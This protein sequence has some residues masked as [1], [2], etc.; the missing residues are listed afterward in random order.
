MP[1]T[2]EKQSP[3]FKNAGKMLDMIDNAILGIVACGTVAVAVA[4]LFDLV[5]DVYKEEKHSFTH[6]LGELMFV[7]IIMELFRQVVRQICRQPFSLQPFMT[8][9]VI[10]C[11]RGLLITQMKIGAGELDWIVGSLET[12]AF[13]LTVLLLIASSYWYHKIQNPV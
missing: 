3:L 1:E 9:G 5:L 6:L 12:L 7:L 8:I 10:A 11:I 2:T 4:L 13:A